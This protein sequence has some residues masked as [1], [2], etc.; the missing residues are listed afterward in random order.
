MHQA[1]TVTLFS[2]DGSLTAKPRRTGFSKIRET[3]SLMHMGLP[4]RWPCFSIV[5][6]GQGKIGTSVPGN[7]L[8][9]YCRVGLSLHVRFI[10]DARA[11]PAGGI[12]I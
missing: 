2:H 11:S 9:G 6:A 4:H 8:P 7:E 1:E 10:P 3:L 5:P 12:R